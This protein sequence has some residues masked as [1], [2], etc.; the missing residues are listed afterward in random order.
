MNEVLAGPVLTEAEFYSLLDGKNRTLAEVKKLSLD[1]EFD[2][3]KR[4]FANHIR[5]GGYSEVY[6]ENRELIS[7]HSVDLNRG[8]RSESTCI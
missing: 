3:A 1:G 8:E 6:F 5:N 7:T 2:A 4:L